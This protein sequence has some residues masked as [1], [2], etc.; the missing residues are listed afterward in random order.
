ML[1]VELG[2]HS[3][4]AVDT[5]QGEEWDS[6]VLEPAEGTLLVAVENKVV[7]GRLVAGQQEVEGKDVVDTLLVLA[8]MNIV[9][10]AHMLLVVEEV[11]ESMVVEGQLLIKV[12][13][14]ESQ[15]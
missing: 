14:E 8:L 10:V 9:A 7:A 12:Q 5:D 13:T 2:C 11:F 4:V 3:T 1:C 15:I 6:S